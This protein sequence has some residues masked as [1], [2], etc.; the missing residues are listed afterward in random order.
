MYMPNVDDPFHLSDWRWERARWLRENN[1]RAFRGTEDD[2]V[3][4]AKEFQTREAACRTINEREALI[5]RFPSI[6]YAKEIHRRPEKVVRWMIEAYLLSKAETAYISE[7][8]AVSENT[9]TWYEKL[10]YNVTP[11]LKS[12]SYIIN[13]VIGTAIHH[14]AVERDFDMVWKLLAY[15]YGPL[16]L[17][18][19]LRV[20]PDQQ[21]TDLD[22][23]HGATESGFQRM[24]VRKSLLG[25]MTI[26]VY[27]NQAIIFEALAR[28]KE[29]A[30]QSGQEQESLMVNNVAM[31]LG[32]LPF[33]VGKGGPMDLPRLAYYDEQ[34]VEL[35][36]HEQIE[37]AMGLENESHRKSMEWKFPES[38]DVIPMSAP[39]A[40]GQG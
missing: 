11:Y 28:H 37:V 20:L 32:A 12:D 8:T 9:I 7:A 2:Y 5:K 26:P 21:V 16:Y 40:G 36:A 3:R 19:W 25:A 38:R 35:R 33:C 30:R 13:V 6:Y 39:D 17:R 24:L 15:A 23:V 10:F 18:D 4:A 27:N 29:I 14:G 1:K 22:Q 31:A 34:S